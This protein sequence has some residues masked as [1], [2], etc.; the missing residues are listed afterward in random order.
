[1]IFTNGVANVKYNS[2]QSW[3]DSWNKIRQQTG[4]WNNQAD[5]ETAN[6]LTQYGD[7]F[8]SL[9]KNYV[10]RDPDGTEVDQFFKTVVAPKGEYADQQALRD[11][12]ASFVGDT[13]QV[14]AEDKVKE[15]LKAQESQAGELSNI[16]RAQGQE[17]VNKYQSS[18]MDF[19]Q[20]LVERVRPNLLTSLQA[21]GLLNT[22]G[23][24][25]AVAGQQADFSNQAAQQ[26]ADLEMQ[27]NQQADAIKFGGQ[28]AAYEFAKGQSMN[29]LP[30]L[31]MAG[32]QG[33]QNA[34]QTQSQNNLFSHQSAMLQ[35]QLAAQ[36]RR[37]SFG[38]T[39]GQSLATSLGSNLGK[40]ADP[41]TWQKAAAP[42]GQV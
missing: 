29:R 20:K 5:E 24:N 4:R 15:E 33:L 8:A 22:G 3:Y 28:S 26:V 38:Q 25:Q 13:F 21:Q 19:T 40:F 16:F 27:N 37:P 2:S 36:N 17:T 30:N 34:Y 14:A 41:G 23:L 12:T 31:L 39:F 1:M 6:T 11:R 32:Q 10:G 42:G 9:F 7:Q 18:L 35:A